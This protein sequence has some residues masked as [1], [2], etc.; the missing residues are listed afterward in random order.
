[1]IERKK[2]LGRDRVSR[3]VSW[4]HWFALFNGFLAMIVGVRF[5]D[6]VG[7]PDTWLGWGYL[8]LST[9]GHFSF[10]AFIVYL[11]MI[12]PVTLLLPYSKI[13]RGY[14]AVVATLSLCILL[15]DTVI[16]DD[17]GLHLSP[18]V[19]D[20]AWEDLNALLQGTS[21]IVTPIGILILE[22]TAANFLWKRIDKIQKVNC[23]NK[24]VAFIGIC[25]VSSHLI[26]IWADAA[27]VHEI[28]RFDDT[29]PLS[30]PATAKTF[31]ESQGVERIASNNSVLPQPTLSYPKAALQCSVTE[32]PNMLFITVESFRADMLDAQTMPFLYQYGQQNQRFN[33]H[34]SGGNTFDSGMFSL[35]YAM[36]GSYINAEDLNYTSP[37]F[38]QKLKQQGY[39]L[40]LFGPQTDPRPAAIFND[41]SAQISQ[42]NESMAETD[43]ISV[44][45]FNQWQHQQ[46]APWFAMVNLKSPENFDTP[47]GFLG[48]ETVRPNSPLRP[49]QK[50]LFNQYRQSL[51][52]I[53][54]QIEAM[55]A[56][57]PANTLVIITGVNGKL[58]SSNHAESRS[59]YSP[60][61]VQ[62]PL[63]VNWP[64]YDKAK[65][66]N[67]RTS[68]YGIVPA[69]MTQLMNCTNPA[70]EYSA[71]RSILSPNS[72]TWTYVGN[73]R[74]FAIYQQNEITV[75]DRH[76]KYRIYNRD[77][78]KRLKKK[79]GA[80]E[81]IQV[82]REGRR[83]YNN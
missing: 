61:N 70:R 3:L 34:L 49:A 83:L 12:F 51:N 41:F 25:F 7:T 77:Y 15:Y 4:G 19:F 60:A 6:S 32:Q 36:Q 50:V 69:I 13:L 71:G 62:V 39:Q 74:Q 26:H 76:G 38:T 79:I 54:G 18:F 59:N 1:M 27:E 63:I 53:D 57:V 46:T 66:V 8:T 55:L 44:Q 33:E 31:M 37:I 23:G 65:D 45:H 48:I 73:N 10:L 2:E 42:D 56:D 30:Y 67:Y 72:E 64:G 43:I 52:F 68:H 21:Y 47:V 80:P 11:V 16:Y 20:I 81:L 28:T 17:Y 35:L 14:A 5:L 40:A 22:L 24:V 82:M 78:D 29:Y 9:I 75:I 58:F